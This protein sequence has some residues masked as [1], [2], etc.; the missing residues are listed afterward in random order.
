MLMGMKLIGEAGSEWAGDK[1]HQ[2][3]PQ[4]R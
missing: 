2:Q 3:P 1:Y 4:N